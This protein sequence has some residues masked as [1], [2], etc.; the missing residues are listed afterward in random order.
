MSAQLAQ[1]EAWLQEAVMSQA[2]SISEAWAL[3]DFALVIPDGESAEL[4]ESMHPTV[5]R[6]FLLEVPVS[7]RLP[8]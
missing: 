5:N 1:L 4:P 8:I 2:V 7:N 3:Q 6:L